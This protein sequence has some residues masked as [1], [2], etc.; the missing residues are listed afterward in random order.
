MVKYAYHNPVLQ[1]RVVARRAQGWELQFVSLGFVWEGALLKFKS[2]ENEVGRISWI[3][4]FFTSI[5]HHASHTRPCLNADPVSLEKF[6]FLWPSE[7]SHNN[8]ALQK[9]WVWLWRER[10]DI[11]KIIPFCFCKN[12]LKVMSETLIKHSKQEMYGE[13]SFSSGLNPP[14]LSF[15]F[16][17][18]HL[19]SFLS[20]SSSHSIAIEIKLDRQSKPYFCHKRKL[21]LGKK[22]KRSVSGGL[23][24]GLSKPRT[25]SEY[26]VNPLEP[27]L[28]TCSSKALST[29]PLQASLS[30]LRLLGLQERGREK[31]FHLP[32]SQWTSVEGDILVTQVTGQ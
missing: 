6:I 22:K 26:G 13:F 24:W 20:H 11:L 16:P 18:S 15:L 19:L 12:S 30:F 29:A 14:V 23:W 27:Q 3:F 21:C 2:V 28:H 31:S 32:H 8:N 17:F 9:M 25:F 5:W 10:C 7:P 4:L 1:P